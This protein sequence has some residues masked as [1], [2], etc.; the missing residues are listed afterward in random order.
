MNRKSDPPSPPPKFHLFST[1]TY[2]RIVAYP[3]IFRIES[4]FKSKICTIDLLYI[5]CFDD[6]NTSGSSGSRF[7]LIHSRSTRISSKSELA[8]VEAARSL[9]A[10]AAKGR[11]RERKRGEQRVKKK[12]R[13]KVEGK[14][15]LVLSGERIRG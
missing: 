10:N 5:E 11:Q 1:R 12:R 8:R 6:H 13:R 4:K 2:H 7:H 15:D 14:R 9:S 3:R